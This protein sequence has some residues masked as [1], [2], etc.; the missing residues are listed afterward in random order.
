M[1][2]RLKKKQ[3]K[4]EV[5]KTADKLLMALG[6]ELGESRAKYFEEIMNK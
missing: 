6:R 2:K 1:N 5:E 3:R 4:K